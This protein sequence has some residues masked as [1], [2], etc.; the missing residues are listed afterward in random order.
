[1][2]AEA[3]STKQ[4]E[5]AP[6]EEVD[7]EESVAAVTMEE[8]PES[9]TAAEIVPPNR[10]SGRF[11][12]LMEAAIDASS[13][14]SEWLFQNDQSQKFDTTTLISMAEMHDNENPLDDDSVYVVLEDG[15]IGERPEGEAVE[16]LFTPSDKDDS[17]RNRFDG[18]IAR[19]GPSTVGFFEKLDDPEILGQE[20]ETGDIWYGMVLDRSN[21][22][23]FT[24]DGQ[25]HTVYRTNIRKSDGSIQVIEEIDSNPMYMWLSKGDRVRYIPALNVYEKYD[26]S[27]DESIPCLLC[28]K[29]NSMSDDRCSECGKPLFK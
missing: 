21:D 25:E 7:R 26:K 18:T 17:F 8:E 20:K 14:S 12:T 9:Q 27:V 16:W 1:M 22:I 2:Q 11:R 19:N 4:E 24:Q 15:S 28:G 10:L 23:A 5:E 13:Y 29:M 6:E 3:E